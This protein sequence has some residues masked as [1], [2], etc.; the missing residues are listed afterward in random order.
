MTPC[1]LVDIQQRLGGMLS[2]R[3]TAEVKEARS[4][5]PHPSTSTCRG[6]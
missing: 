1:H 4:Y 2:S 3:Y 6:N 5:C